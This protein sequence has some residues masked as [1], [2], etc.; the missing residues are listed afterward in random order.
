MGVRISC[1]QG[2]SR[3]ETPTTHLPLKDRLGECRLQFG[4]GPYESEES[5]AK[6]NDSHLK[7]ESAPKDDDRCVLICRNH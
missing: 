7:G 2:M 3:A 5:Y 6:S 4:Q 1:L